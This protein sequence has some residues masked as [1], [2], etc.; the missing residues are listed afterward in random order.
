MRR[1]L[2][3]GLSALLSES[4]EHYD[5]LEQD[6]HRILPISQLQ[7]NPEQ[8]RQYFEESAL[9]ELSQSIKT[10]GI[11][12]PILVRRRDHQSYEIVA[13]ER[14]WRAATRAGLSSVP[15]IIRELD[16]AET[17]EIGLLENIQ[18]QDLTAIEEAKGYRELLSRFQH[19]QETLSQ[20]VHK[21][22]SHIAN[23]I[24]LLQLPPQ[25]Q[26]QVEASQ[27]SPG[28]AKLLVGL[29]N[30]EALA[31]RAIKEH[32]SVRQLEQH[33]QKQTMKG[34]QGSRSPRLRRAPEIMNLEEQLQNQLGVDVRITSKGQ[35]GWISLQYTTLDEL[36]ALVG[37]L[38]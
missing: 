31:T 13:G 25:I 36:D 2:G 4:A 8:P 26:Q 34:E 27:L 11:L 19:T 3:K 23:T 29:P 6:E 30:A 28:H 38:L 5:E 20:I 33:L 22:R 7:P 14:R 24:R 21:S 35:K 12:Q 37:K 15:C 10:K 17:L 1:S 16:D 32:W 9:E 18:R